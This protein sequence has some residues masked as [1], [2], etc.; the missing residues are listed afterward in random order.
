MSGNVSVRTVTEA[1]LT[2]SDNGRTDDSQSSSDA[3]EKTRK[4][5]KFRRFLRI[6]EKIN[7]LFILVF[8]CYLSWTIPAHYGLYSGKSG[9]QKSS[10]NHTFFLQVSPI[11][12]DVTIIEPRHEKTSVLVSDLVRHKPGCIVHLQ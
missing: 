8:V 7:M 1:A 2:I 4:E 6:F 5:Q 11:V 10:G 3:E 9:S 12:C